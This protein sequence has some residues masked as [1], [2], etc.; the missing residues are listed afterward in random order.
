MKNTDLRYYCDDTL[1]TNDNDKWQYLINYAF[2]KA[3]TVEF[4]ILNSNQE[5]TPEIE[6][7]SNDLI[8]K[9]ERRNKIYPSGSYLRYKLTDNIKNFIKAK[10]YK[11]WYNYNIE[12]ISFLKN[13]KEFLATITH[14]NYVILQSTEEQREQLKE[15]GFNFWCDWGVDPAAENKKRT[16]ERTKRKS[17]SLIERLK[18]LMNIKEKNAS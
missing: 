8:E 1:K 12:D 5:L 6:A 16:Q 17:M 4:N 3:D 18:N 15:E 10:Q 14:E 9:S 11:D 13:D 2:K 7:L